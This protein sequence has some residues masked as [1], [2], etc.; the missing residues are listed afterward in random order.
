MGYLYGDSSPFPLKENFIETLREA[1]DACVALLQIDEALDD[2]YDRADETKAIA[3]R[4]QARLEA[5]AGSLVRALE[6]PIGD[7]EAPAAAQTAVRV[8]QAARQVLEGARAESANRRDDAL[9]QVET[10]IATQRAGI[11]RAL[12][13]FLA[14]RELPATVWRLR[15]RAGTESV[16]AQ[17]QVKGTTPCR[18]DA[19]MEID[20]PSSH[21]FARPVRVQ[22][23]ERD[24]VIH[25]PREGGLLRR[26][27]RR[28]ERLDRFYVTEVELGPERC[29]FVVRRGIK[30]PS[31]GLEI[32]VRAD[33]Q[34]R[35]TAKHL[36]PTG[37]GLGGTVTLDGVDGAAVERLWGRIEA[38][39]RDLVKRRTRLVA[40]HLDGVP[41]RDVD[42][43][44]LIAKLV[45]DELAPIVREMRRRS[46]S[47]DELVLKRDLGGGRREEI[48]MPRRE[49]EWKFAALS[50]G[51]RALFDA[52]ELGGE[53]TG[54][55]E[56]REVLEIS[57]SDET[58]D[59]ALIGATV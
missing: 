24:V 8:L 32:V 11:L 39:V 4:E 51:R 56:V 3:V 12:E 52:Y 43:P 38:N 6:G 29:A 22:E 54:E 20:I 25:L 55:L 18:L 14:R 46:A 49:L 21:A 7:Q 57:S 45:V 10:T 37:P 1:T 58:L 17:A 2:A 59:R 13:G 47:R 15:W 33:G 48:F 41:V 5:L 40:A 36:S 42:R 16:P 53:L 19:V 50:P 35:P 26:A 30:A 23:L 28:P 34:G 44:A 31:D 9:R 27:G